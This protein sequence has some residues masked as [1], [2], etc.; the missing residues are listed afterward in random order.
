MVKPHPTSL[1]LYTD[2]LFET[3]CSISR[4]TLPFLP[5]P[6]FAEPQCAPFAFTNA[7]SWDGNESCLPT[8]APPLIS[9]L[10]KP[11]PMADV[12]LPIAVDRLHQVAVKHG[13]PLRCTHLTS[14]FHE[15]SQNV[16]RWLPSLSKVAACSC[17]FRHT[18]AAVDKVDCATLSEPFGIYSWNSKSLPPRSH[19][20]RTGSLA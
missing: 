5:M 18:A 12:N 10:S 19:S 3:A 9:A 7:A 11:S 14:S 1:R 4:I 17:D 6:E 20:D 16:D 13:V 15:C 8:F 2:L